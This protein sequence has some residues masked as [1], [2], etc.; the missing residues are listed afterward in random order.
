MVGLVPAIS[1]KDALAFLSEIAGP[2]P[3]MTG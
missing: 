1:L 2:S 3:A